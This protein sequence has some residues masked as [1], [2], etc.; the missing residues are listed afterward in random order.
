[1]V[2]TDWPPYDSDGGS[3]RA[4]GAPS[5]FSIFPRKY[6]PAE[7]SLRRSGLLRLR[8]GGDAAWIFVWVGTLALRLV[9]AIL[10]ATPQL[11]ASAGSDQKPYLVDDF[12]GPTPLQGWRFY[13]STDSP[14]AGG[15]LTLG[16][17]HRD[18]GAVLAYR[19]PCERGTS[20]GANA[21]ALWI[22]PGSFPKIK[23]PA[24]SLWI[25][26][27]LEVDVFLVAKDTGGR[28]L[29]FAIP[30][31]TIEHPRSGDWQYVVIPL[32]PK[33]ADD[34]GGSATGGIKG[35]PV[36]IGIQVQA[37]AQVTVQGSVSFD[38]VSLRELSETFHVDS[39]TQV[40]PPAPEA[41]E[42]GSRLGVNI[43]LLR[44]DPALDLARTAG[45][46]FVRMDM[47]WA[48]VERGGR[49]RF[50][51][52]DA[53]LRSLD[54]RGM[55]VLWILDY[56]HPDH[57]GKTPRTPEDVA[58][59]GR[60]AEAAATH[61]KG[62]NIRYEVWNEPN[63]AQFWEP[64]PSASEYGVLLREAVAAIRRAD[65]SAK[66]SSGGVSRL[67]LSFLSRAVPPALAAN[68]TAVGIHPYPKLGPEAIAP[69]LATLRE[70]VARALG[71]HIEIWDTEW[72]YSSTNA[73]K[74]APSNGHTEQGRR[75]QAILAVREL[76][77]V[78]TLGFPLAVW[79]DLRDDGTDPAN[80]EHNYGLLDSSGKEKPAMQA[81]RTLMSALS[82]RKYAG[83]IP[84]TPGGIHAMRFDG[85]ADT[86]FVVWND[87]SNNR[88]VVEYGK[89][90]LIS[91]TDGMGRPLKSKNRPSGHVEVELPESAGPIYLQWTT[92]SPHS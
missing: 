56:G 22:P 36:E 62:R 64:S 14:T 53:L 30:R 92:G 71:E 23:N 24:I 17:G 50:F 39:A 60:F 35:R 21:A 90:G 1:M 8:R 48:D 42:L 65:P 29:R 69:E 85:P 32:S 27:P 4:G 28:M 31:A 73:P 70:W 5:I 3:L 79:Y 78:W 41:L 26:F 82:G 19:L 58:A 33:P 89:E 51:P 68:L 16:P 52:Y 47:L 2:G 38:D 81:I 61:F 77:T 6:G 59:F 7:S 12:D 75:R 63:N 9:A 10:F 15:A 25:R 67:D 88:R 13:S 54:A 40:I 46:R 66:V 87:Q 45:F 34:A 57:G 43:H 76:L 55:G 83:M 18:R 49:Y 91:A 80:P 44:D 74:E 72:G 84:E 20:C 11:A 86:T 37:R